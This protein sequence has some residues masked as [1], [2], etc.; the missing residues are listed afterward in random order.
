MVQVINSVQ[1]SKLWKSA[2]V[3]LAVLYSSVFGVSVLTIL[4]FVYFFAFREMRAQIKNTINLEIAE[5]EE[6]FRSDGLNDT[7]DLLDQIAEQDVEGLTVYILADKDD[8]VLATNLDKWPDDIKT[9]GEWIRFTLENYIGKKAEN[10]TVLAKYATFP[11]GYNLIFGYSLKSLERLQKNFLE[12]LLIAIVVT[13]ILSV[14]GGIVFTRLIN[15]RLMTINRTCERIMSGQLSERVEESGSGDEFDLLAQNFNAMLT[16]I[17]ILI[18][19][20]REVSQSIAHDLRT[21]LN[22]LRNRLEEIANNPSPATQEEIRTAIKDVDLLVATFNAILR[23]SHAESGTGITEFAEFDISEAARKT[24]DFY[25]VIAEEKSISISTNIA[26]G[27]NFVGDKHLL[28]Q[29]FA[30]LLDN[31]IKYTPKS[32]KVHVS[33]TESERKIIFSIQDTGTG[34]P[35]EFMEKVKQKFFRLEQ[36]RTTPGSGLGLS[37]VDAVVK[38]HKGNLILKNANPGLIVE[39]VLGLL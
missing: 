10:V 3:R 28:T 27:I 6:N 21:P 37:L 8:K 2:A 35:E 9:R 14:V 34:I 19:T 4:I 1:V 31:A 29:A 11:G 15:R 39:I 38:L 22:R 32:G 20:M 30:N 24:V 7:I 17:N 36:S 23:I 12:V 13:I 16:Q 5:L 26:E 25:S 18:E 33:L